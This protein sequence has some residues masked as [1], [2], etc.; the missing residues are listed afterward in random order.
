VSASQPRGSQDAAPRPL[1]NPGPILIVVTIG[2]IAVIVAIASILKRPAVPAVVSEDYSRVAARLLVPDVRG[3]DAAAVAQG[4][5]RRQP[6]LS[7]RLPSL[8]EA[9][10]ALEGGALRAIWNRPGVVAI[11]RNRR[12]DVLVTHIYQGVLAD[13]PGPPEVR[14]VNNRTFIIHRKANNILVFWQDGPV[15]MVVTSSLPIEQVIKLA[16]AAARSVEAKN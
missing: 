7:V 10:Y 2:A 13:L 9:G 6:A 1:A 5:N 3:A 11:Y 12:M 8:D 16:D 14:R 15:V 4:L